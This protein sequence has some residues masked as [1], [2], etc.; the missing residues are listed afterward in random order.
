M[1]KLINLLFLSVAVVMFTGCGAVVD[2]GLNTLSSLDINKLTFG[3]KIQGYNNSSQDVELIYCNSDYTYY[4]GSESF[5]GSF[6]INGSGVVVNMYD[7]AGGSY[8]LDTYNGYIEVGSY[9][10]IDYVSDEITVTDIL[11]ITCQ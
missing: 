3:Y 10:T 6:T 1:K 2:D 4:R 9:Y 5:Y 8:I 11:P 7:D